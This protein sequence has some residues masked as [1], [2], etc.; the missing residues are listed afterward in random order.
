MW[1]GENF[2]RTMRI[3]KKSICKV[4]SVLILMV[5]FFPILTHGQTTDIV[6]L[7]AEETDKLRA[8][9][10]KNSEVQALNDSIKM[11]ADKGLTYNPNP[12]SH[13]S[14]EGMLPTHPDRIATEK[15]LED[16][17]K[18][19]NLI[20]AS[21]GSDSDM[22]GEKAKQFVV[23]WSNTYIPDGNP[24]NENKLTALFWA[25]HLFKESFS[26]EQKQQV[27]TWMKT[28]ADKELARAKTPNN[29]W[30]AK[31]LKII[32]TIGAILNLEALNEYA[33]EGFKTYIESAYYADGTSNDLR[34]RDALRYH[35]SGLMP[36]VA[37]FVNGVSF[38]DRYNLF[39]YMGPSG[40]S[41]ERSVDYVVPYVT[42]ELQREEWTNSKA[43]I[44]KK[45]AAAGLAEYQ[46][47]VLYDPSHAIP[48]FEW[49]G[50]FRE[51]TY[52][53]F[54][55]LPAAYTSSW[56]GLLNSPLVRSK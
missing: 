42:G 22:Y 5:C 46:P 15:S 43:A 28:I 26:N 39:D 10:E 13:L 23:A 45:R 17:D 40:S 14:Y 31:R 30:E 24:I 53:L 34:E 56:V 55:E 6:I 51:D 1:H 41:V 2:F 9:L 25:Y 33:L 29:N 11:L 4:C 21:Y 16:M 7:N 18:V 49:V 20:Y 44:D 38:D 54:G 3:Q 48:L 37:V 32:A 12:L 52:M 19:V 8:L 47:G 50:Y 35:V 27:E 36:T